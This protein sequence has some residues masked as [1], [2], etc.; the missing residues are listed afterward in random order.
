MN[1]RWSLKKVPD[2]IKSV[3]KNSLNFSRD[4]RNLVQSNL[5]ELNHYK[6]FIDGL[7]ASVLM[8]LSGITT[9]KILTSMTPKKSQMQ[10]LLATLAS[11]LFN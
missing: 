5:A 2:T 1:Q 11:T 3:F 8:Q 10:R 6:S 9:Q 4:K 7:M